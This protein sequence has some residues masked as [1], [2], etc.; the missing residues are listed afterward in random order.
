LINAPAPMNSKA[1]NNA[2]V[3]I[4]KNVNIGIFSA[5]L[6]IIIPSCLN[7]DNAIIFFMSH[8]DKALSPAINIVEVAIIRS[9]QLNHL[10]ECMNG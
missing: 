5:R 9:M 3:I 8:S 7:V 10:Y 4:W 6:V 2:C 1:L